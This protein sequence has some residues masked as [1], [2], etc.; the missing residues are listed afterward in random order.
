VFAWNGIRRDPGKIEAIGRA[1]RAL[2][3]QGR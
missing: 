3:G 2:A 1:F